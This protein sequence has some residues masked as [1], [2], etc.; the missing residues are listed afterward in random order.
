[1]KNHVKQKLISIF[2]D[3]FIVGIIIFGVLAINAMLVFQSGIFNPGYLFYAKKLE[4]YGLV[5]ANISLVYQMVSMIIAIYS[6]YKILSEDFNSNQIS[7]YLANKGTKNKYFLSIFIASLL[8]QFI[9]LIIP[10]AHYIIYFFI[11]KINID[12]L[13]LSKLFLSVIMNTTILA[14]SSLIVTL[15]V[16]SFKSL[17]AGL[18]FLI[19]YEL[20]NF[21]SL[22]FVGF[23]LPFSKGLQTVLITIFPVINP[24]NEMLIRE[25]ISAKI[26]YTNLFKLDNILYQL[27]FIAFLLFVYLSMS[28]RVKVSR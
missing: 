6:G 28:L 19:W 3:S 24:L 15:K 21:L 23:K 2:S 9:L 14:L 10:L 16:K 20:A 5:E 1:M 27:I 12:F 18:G 11:L 22:P 17:L 13:S 8:A 4:V 25:G 7:I 26:S